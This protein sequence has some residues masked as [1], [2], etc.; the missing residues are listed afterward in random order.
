MSLCLAFPPAPAEPLRSPSLVLLFLKV[1][2][3]DSSIGLPL[4]ATVLALEHRLMGVAPPM[5]YSSTIACAKASSCSETVRRS[6]AAPGNAPAIGSTALRLAPKSGWS[7]SGVQG[8]SL[9]MSAG[10]VA[11]ARPRNSVSRANR[12][13][14]PGVFSPAITH[15]SDLGSDTEG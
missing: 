11:T 4:R 7:I 12:A 13:L 1:A 2:G 6:L 9:L 10:S 5:A 3:I 15:G 8:A 14:L